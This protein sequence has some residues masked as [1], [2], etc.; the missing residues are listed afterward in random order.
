MTSLMRQDRYRVTASVDNK[1]LGVF[2][3][4]TGGEATSEDVKHARGGG[5]QERALGGRQTTGNVTISRIYD[6]DERE[7]DLG[8][9]LNRRGKGEMTVTRQP[10]DADYN[11][12]GKAIIYTGILQRVAPGNTDSHGADKDMLELE[13]SCNGPVSRS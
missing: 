13:M 12:K 1:P 8:W 3:T 4:F 9:L 5:G 2:D 11:P 6:T 7:F 10:L